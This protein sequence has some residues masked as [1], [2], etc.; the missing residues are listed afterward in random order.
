MKEY[1]SDVSEVMSSVDSSAT[2]L[3]SEEAEKRLEKHGKNKL[4]AAKK[5]SIFTRF[6]K[7]LADP[8]IIILICAAAV[9]GII[10]VLENESF[11]DVIIILAV[12]IINAVLGVYQENK[13]EH[14][15]EAL[16]E[17]SAATSKVLRN[18]ETVIIKSEDIVP[19]DIVFLEAGDAVPADGRIIDSAS[20]KIEEAALTGESV[21]VNK[22][23]DTLYLKEN[24]KDIPLGDRKNMV[25][26]GS[27][28]VY[29]RG[30]ILVTGTGMDTEMGKIANA[31]TQAEEGQT[32]LQVKLSQ[33]SKILTYLVLGICV[34]I[35]GVQI[36]RDGVSADTILGSFMVAVSLAVAAI[37]EG[38]SMVVTV[39]LSIGVTH[40]SKKNAII[41]HLTA[42]ETLGCAQIICSDKT[43]TLTQNKMTVVKSYG[44]D[45]N[46]VAESFAL[47]TDAKLAPGK[48]ESTGDPTQ[49]AV[50]DFAAK[51][52]LPKYELEEQF[53]RIGEIPF[54]SMRKL[55]T[56]VHENSRDGGFIQHTTGAPD[57]V[58]GK[59]T[60]VYRNGKI[61]PMTDEIRAELAAANKGLADQALRV[62]ASGIRKYESAPE[63]FEP[64]DLE[65]DLCFLGL[66]G[67]IDP[68]RPEVK[69][70]IVECR[71]AGIRPIMITGDHRDTAVAIAKELG[72]IEEGQYAITGA[73]LSEMDDE[74]FAKEFR[75]ISVYARVQPEHKTRI[76]NQW[77]AAGYVT[78]MTGDG[79]NDAPSIKSADIGVGMGITGT[80]VTKNV[81]DMVLAD[82]NFATIVTAVEEGRRIYDNIRKTI[83]FLLGSNM[84]EV[85]TIFI[86]TLLGFTV[87]K[88]VHLLWINLITDTFPALALG[89]EKAEA[90]IM[91]RKPRSAKEG[92]FAGGMGFDVAY[93]GLLVSILVLVSYAIGNAMGGGEHGITM[94]FLTLSMA[95]IFHSFNLRSQRKS[96]FT[97]KSMNKYL[98]VAAVASFILTTAVCEIPFLANAFQFAHVGIEEYLIAIALGIVVIPVVEI[99]KLIQRKIAQKRA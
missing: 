46:L 55:M 74:T 57:V 6:M 82:D 35:F 16:Q 11:A 65:C 41:R 18:G 51:L 14:A 59:C 5:D 56:T 21:P 69:D 78:A 39:V 1:L 36:I 48:T 13:A 2:G 47:C 92:V 98:T 44:D 89:M 30:T 43:G 10:A 38:L 29:G 85:I 80:D 97:I 37:P 28:V 3:T 49:T 70:A 20:L 67:M 53:K 90:D 81:A 8:M 77:R 58:I 31:L 19:G 76:V 32:P 52:G 34:L 68:V 94:A 26:M 79:V 23:I 50:V 88:P 84:S 7:Q 22:L 73:E 66:V 99:V 71:S 75:N 12:V 54:D 87:L 9:S 4:K 86:A 91:Q 40:M 17:M 25:Y 72:I 15:I 93:Q 62:L 60:S 95:E 42:V 33:L 45:E 61:V 96:I 63:S 64:A 27:T 83:Q 24:E